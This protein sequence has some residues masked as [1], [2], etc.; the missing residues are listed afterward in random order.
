MKTYGYAR[1]STNE[2]R[3]D[4]ERQARELTAK[5]AAEII[6]EYASGAKRE[7]EGLSTL[8]AGLCAGDTLAVTEVSRLTRSLRQLCEI[9]EEV[10][11]KKIRLICGT[12]ETDCTAAAMDPMNKAMLQMMGVF[13]EFERGAT[14]ERIK[15]GLANAKAKGTKIGRPHKTAG[16]VPKPVKDLLPE[17]Q[18]GKLGKAE[19]ARKAGV[20]RQSLYKYLRLLGQMPPTGGK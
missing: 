9:L 20:T 6:K 8:M 4:I 13:A 7:R 18:A 16:E 10:E 14:V 15:S 1:C 19:Y 12:M 17:Y 11:A 5:G 2:S 3:Q